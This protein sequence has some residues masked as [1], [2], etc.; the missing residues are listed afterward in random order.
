MKNQEVEAGEVV[1]NKTKKTDF[2]KVD[3]RNIVIQDGFNVRQDLGDIEGLAQSI[4][5]VGL[6]VPLKA[7]KVFGA[8]KYALVDGHRRYHAIMLAIEN[9]HDIRYVD[10]MPY[11]GNDE[12]QIFSMLVTGTGQKPLADIEQSEAVARLVNFGYKVE[13]IARKMGKSLPHGYY[14]YNLSMLSK[15]IK[16]LISQGYISGGAVMEIVKMTD[17]EQEQFDLIQETIENAQNGAAEGQIKKATA[18]NISKEKK[19]SP[20]QKLEALCEE[21]EKEGLEGQKVDLV[22]ELVAMAKDKETG[23]SDLMFLF[24]H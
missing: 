3:P 1:I 6:Q 4:V 18:K 14:L 11:V 17:D 23:V 12:D 21:L 9:G 15:R 8:D 24:Q 22:I 5:E 16:N 2:V 13:E 19:L 10:V 7:K 20:I